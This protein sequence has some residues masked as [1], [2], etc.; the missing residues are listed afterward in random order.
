MSTSNHGRQAM[1]GASPWV[2]PVPLGAARTASW[3]PRVPCRDAAA[4]V[5]VVL[6]SMVGARFT[7]RFGYRM[8]SAVGLAGVALSLGIDVLG[9]ETRNLALLGIGL[10]LSGA[11]LGGASVA[12]TAAGLAAVN[13]FGKGVASGLLSSTAK[14]GT[15]LGFALIP[16][17]GAAW[18]GAG[19]LAEAPS[20]STD[21]GRGFRAAFLV[22]ALVAVIAIPLAW[23]SFGS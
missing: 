10:S 1:P 9:V 3:P 21:L 17:V 5:A 7:D 8:S 14:I 6:G 15:A 2:G 16:A 18:I 23:S 20:P 4:S 19:S 22:A 12:S 13:D 11:A